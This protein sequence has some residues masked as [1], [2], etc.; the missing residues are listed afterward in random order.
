MPNILSYY[1]D[2]LNVWKNMDITS[3][4]KCEF[5]TFTMLIHLTRKRILLVGFEV[6]MAENLD[7]KAM[8]VDESPMFGGTNYFHL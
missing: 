6:L 3:F 8:Q 5:P 4:S 2:N 7:F 1:D